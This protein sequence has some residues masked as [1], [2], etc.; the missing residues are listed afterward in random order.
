MLVVWGSIGN[1]GLGGRN[2]SDRGSG[3]EGK[4]V[5]PKE[6]GVCEMSRD[7]VGAGSGES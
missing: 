4:E 3:M 1:G 7:G 2:L 6:V 5:K